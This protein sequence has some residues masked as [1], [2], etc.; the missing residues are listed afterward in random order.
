[1]A[2]TFYAEWDIKF[3]DKILRHLYQVSVY[4]TLKM[5]KVRRYL[6][7]YRYVI[8]QKY[9]NREK[10]GLFKEKIWVCWLQG[11]ENAPSLVKVCIDSICKNAGS[12]EVILLDRKNIKNYIEL[13][14]Y[15]LKK[16]KKDIITAAQFSDILRSAIL[17]KYGGTWIDATV[18]CTQPIAEDMLDSELFC[19]KSNLLDKGMSIKAS[20]WFIS[21]RPGNEVMVKVR[22]LLYEYWKREDRL[23]HYYLF[24]IFFSM[25][26]ESS[27]DCRRIWSSME[28]YSMV[29][30]H[31]LQYLLNQKYNEQQWSTIKKTASLHKL[32]HRIVTA[33]RD[34]YYGK[35]IRGELV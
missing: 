18:Y 35:I 1:M 5:Q 8:K 7:K 32:N 30:V 15:V 9:K 17:A 21:C 6:E 33:S 26:T 19:F 28:F 34:S 14:Q 16:Y 4:E 24:H 23:I 29:Y 22:D 11:V 25:A 12:R 27:P 3:A 2:K 20:S 31:Q 13:P 10:S